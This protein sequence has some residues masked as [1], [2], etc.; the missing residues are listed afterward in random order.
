LVEK[1]AVLDLYHK[2]L[3]AQAALPTLNFG[4]RNNLRK[5]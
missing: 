3:A 4:M 5:R 2:K 1:R